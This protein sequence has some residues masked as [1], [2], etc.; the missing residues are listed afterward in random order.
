MTNEVTVINQDKP[1]TALA[2]K[3]QVNLIQEVMRDV[4]KEGEHYGTIPGCGDKKVL[5]KAGAEKLAMT[6]RLCPEFLIERLNLENNHREY[7]VTCTLKTFSGQILA[8]GVGSCTTLETKYR[9]RKSETVSGIEV[10]KGYWDNRD[11]SILLAKMGMG[12]GD[13]GPKKVDGKWFIATLTKGENPDVA[14][15]YNTVLKMAKKRAQVD[16]TITATAA[17]DIFTQ[18][19]EEMEP[20]PVEAPKRAKKV[21][22]PSD[23]IA[24]EEIAPKTAQNGDQG[25]Y[26]YMFDKANPDF[27]KLIGICRNHKAKTGGNWNSEAGAWIFPE[28]CE[29]LKD[30]LVEAQP[31]KIGN[32]ELTPFTADEIPF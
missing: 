18:D 31:K 10:P 8:Q 24:P 22:S 9:Y 20:E 13:V 11:K 1:L 19:L 25:S 15:L 6:F 30:Y 12:S 32:I 14:D 16:A 29:A 26:S 2:V 7:I 23:D 3:T 27:P 28:P 21:A 4:M 5:L 17:S